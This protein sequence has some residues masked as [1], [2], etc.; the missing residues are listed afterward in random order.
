M[1]LQRKKSGAERA[2]RCSASIGTEIL[3]QGD[4]DV[5]LL[6]KYFLTAAFTNANSHATHHI[7]P[8]SVPSHHLSLP[9]APAARIPS[10]ALPPPPF[11]KQHPPP[12]LAALPAL[13]PSQPVHPLVASHSQAASTPAP[14]HATPGLALP[15]LSPSFAPAGVAA[16][17]AACGAPRSANQTRSYVTSHARRCARAE[18]IS[19]AACV[20][21]SR[22]W[23]LS[24]ERRGR[25]VQLVRE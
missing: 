3:G 13:L 12:S 9:P 16:P 7:H 4:T 14:H 2:R 10:H 8:K 20:A 11:L 23:R 18:G 1:D 25:N 22:L 17:H 21:R 6:A 5:S 15:A 19:A 24:Q